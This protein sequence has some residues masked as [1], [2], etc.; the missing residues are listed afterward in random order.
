MNFYGFHIGDYA[1][2]TRHL[3]WEEDLAYRRLLDVYYGAERPLPVDHKAIYRLVVAQTPKQKQA[4]DTVLAEFF[5]LR[6]DGYHNERCDDELAAHALKRD[7]ARQSAEARWSKQEPQQTQ[8]DRN[9]NASKNGM[10]THSE[11]NAP[12]TQPHSHSQKD[13]SVVARAG[14]S[15]LEARLREAAGWQSDPS[16]NLFVTGPIEGLLSNGCDLELDVLPV[17]KAIAPKARG[18]SWKYF[19]TAIAQARDDRIAAATV[20]T[21]PND[22]RPGNG[23]PGSRRAGTYELI[24]EAFAGGDGEGDEVPGH[25]V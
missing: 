21:D 9:A 18:R 25:A 7:K 10:R 17:I 3:S 19:V 11:G 12:T 8:S 24:A 5:K 14:P 15:D 6:D 2:K 22:R 4:V 20:V 1:S 23:K 13:S 16:P